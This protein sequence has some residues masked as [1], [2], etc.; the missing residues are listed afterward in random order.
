MSNK[1]L[2]QKAKL[3]FKN[4]E[5]VFDFPIESWVEIAGTLVILLEIPADT[6]YNENVF[7][8]SLSEENVK[9][10]IAKRRYNEVFNQRCPFI[11]ITIQKN[12][13]RLNNWCSIYFV[14]NPLTG[15][16]LEEG[17]TR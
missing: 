12:K 3:I 4:S 2:I 1:Y 17:E 11:D 6:K 9:W 16:I 13:V 14:V 10:Q 5:L 8:V 15:E 7:G